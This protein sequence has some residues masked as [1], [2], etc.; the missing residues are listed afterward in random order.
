MLKNLLAAGVRSRIA[1]TPS[2]FLHAGNGLNFILTWAL[3]RACGGKLLLRID[4]LDKARYRQEYVEDIFA[5][6]EWLGI[7]YDEGPNSVADFEQNWS[8]HHR[9]A[10]YEQLLNTLRAGEL[11]FACSCSRKEIRNIS[12]D[13]RYPNTCVERSLSFD[14]ENIAWRIVPP[15]PEATVEVRDYQEGFQAHSLEQLDAFVVRQKNELP[16][17]QIASLAD[18]LYFGINLIVRG[19]DLWTST[20]SQMHLAN[21]LQQ[22]DFTNCCFLHHPLMRDPDGEKMSKS[23]GANALKSWRAEGRTPAFLYQMAAPILKLPTGISDGPGLI[24]AIK[25]RYLEN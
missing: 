25:E 14:A 23:A 1:P 9:I 22:G 2:G 3:T 7:D 20:L 18:D 17:Y 13:G 24:Q 15:E 19:K 4:D 12:P 6:L 10:H 5:T 21:L 11:L 16:A 8:Q